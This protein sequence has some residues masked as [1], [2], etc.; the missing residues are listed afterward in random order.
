MKKVDEGVELFDEIWEKV[1]S[2]EQQNQK[3]KYEVDLKKEIK[4]LQRL[5]DQIKTWI[6]SSDVKDKDA[7]LDARRLIETKMEQFKVCE[8]ETKTKTYSKEGLARQDKLSPEE[9]AKENTCKWIAEIIEQLNQLVD[10]RDVEIE[11]LSSGKGKK[12]NKHIIYEYNEFISNHKYHISKLEGIMRLVMNDR[13]DAELVDELKE[14]LEYYVE[15]YEEDE[16]IQGYDEEL[17]YET[18]GLDEMDVVNVDRVTQ[19]PSVSSKSKNDDASSSS[20]TKREK[21]ASKKS[22]TPGSMIPLTIGRARSSNSKKE[23]KE[24]HNTPTKA[25]RSSSSGSNG[26]TLSALGPTPTTRAPPPPNHSGGASMAAVLKREGEQQEKERQKQ[27]A[28][29]QAQQQV[30]HNNNNN[31][32]NLLL[33]LDS[34]FFGMKCFFLFYKR[35]MCIS[36]LRNTIFL[37]FGGG[38]ELNIVY[39]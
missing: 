24:T 17:F 32:N 33:L 37:F 12:S 38:G 19:A 6:G 23:D 29:Q 16:F 8:K 4:K 2:A 31:N 34:F 10:D 3:E 18:L 13:L 26:S 30:R 36:F 28:I 27:A 21:T 1:Y 35:I 9:E 22:S 11:R 15:A 39:D 14:D 20:S 7:L 5:R 25:V